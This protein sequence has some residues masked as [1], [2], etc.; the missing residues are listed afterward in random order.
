MLDVNGLKKVNDTAGHQAGDQ[1]LCNASKM[2]CEIFQQSPVFR[3]GG[4]EFVVIAQGSDYACIE[5]LVHK[6][7]EHN[8]EAL[9]SGGAVVACGM[10]K[11]EN[12]ACVA[13]VFDR[14]DH[15]MYKNKSRLKSE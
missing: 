3:V 7:E 5:K 6:V 13:E 12:D 9:Q 15:A 4:D 2:I 11:F 10:A 1:L 14:A 8:V